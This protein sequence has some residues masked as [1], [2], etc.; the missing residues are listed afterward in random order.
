MTQM[1]PSSNSKWLARAYAFRLRP[2]QLFARF[3]DSPDSASAEGYSHSLPAARHVL[4]RSR[5][6]TPRPTIPAV[7]PIKPQTGQ[8][9]VLL[10]L[11][12]SRF[13]CLVAPTAP[14]ES[15]SVRS[16]GEMTL[17]SMERV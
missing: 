15:S 6:N 7:V 10:A 12:R 14:Q 17:V 3:R 9:S 8:R 11:K 5:I 4:A 1:F 2:G 13:R 16:W